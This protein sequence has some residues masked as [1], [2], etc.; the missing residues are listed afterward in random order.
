MPRTKTRR[1]HKVP[2][3]GAKQLH[4]VQISPQVRRLEA[5]RA[6]AA[7]HRASAP[8]LAADGQAI[9]AAKKSARRSVDTARGATNALAF[10]AMAAL[11]AVERLRGKWH[12][13]P[14][15]GVV[16][17]RFNAGS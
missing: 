3:V 13:H 4:P 8:V 17:V 15:Q 1:T 10:D 7:A 16:G 6:R 9:A 14:R 11:Q 12:K 2:V 5:K